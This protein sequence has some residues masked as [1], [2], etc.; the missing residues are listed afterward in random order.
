MLVS[1][2]DSV[3]D[4]RARAPSPLSCQSGAVRPKPRVLAEARPDF[5][6]VRSLD[7]MQG[8]L[9]AADWPAED[10]KAIVD[11]PV[12][13]CRMLVPGV[14]LPDLARGIPGW[15]VDQ[16]YHEIGHRRSVVA[17]SDTRPEVHAR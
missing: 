16:P 14:L 17:A 10:D 4:R 1:A 12:H 5:V 13:E 11:Q 2:P 8:L 9:A 3:A 15:R 6:L 7:G